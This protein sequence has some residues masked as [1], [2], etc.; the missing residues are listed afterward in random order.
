MKDYLDDM[1][2]VGPAARY[3]EELIKEFDQAFRR[4]KQ[5]KKLIDFNDIEHYALEILEHEEAAAEY[6]AKFECIFVDEYQD[7][8]KRQ[9][10]RAIG[11]VWISCRT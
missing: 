4:A 7:V 10:W 3:L 8:Y 2:S 1:K 6:R 5:E 9:G 11:S